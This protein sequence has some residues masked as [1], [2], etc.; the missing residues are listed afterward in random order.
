MLRIFTEVVLY[1]ASS[2]FQSG[3]IYP[4][5]PSLHPSPSPSNISTPS[6]SPIH[7]PLRSS[8][9]R[10]LRTRNPVNP[11]KRIHYSNYL[12]RFVSPLPFTFSSF[13]VSSSVSLYKPLLRE[14]SK[15]VKISLSFPSPFSFSFFFPFF[16]FFISLYTTRL[17]RER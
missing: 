2:R 11:Y 9:A 7:I 6:L 14:E 12:A 17:F 3:V 4:L 5:C 1:I 8:Q 16:F 13:T 15:T 10:P